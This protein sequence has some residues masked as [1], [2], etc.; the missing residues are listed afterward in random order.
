[1]SDPFWVLPLIIIESASTAVL[2]SGDVIVS[3]ESSCCVV[4]TTIGVVA[5]VI[6]FLPDEPRFLEFATKN[7]AI[8]TPAVMPRMIAISVSFFM[9][10]TIL[11]NCG[12]IV[13]RM[14][15]YKHI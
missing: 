8:E 14:I 13:N 1:M 2:F 9:S 7:M 10:S 5:G 4:A 3:G 12:F 15:K 6:T 11:L